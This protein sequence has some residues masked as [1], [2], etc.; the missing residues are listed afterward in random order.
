M[1][2]TTNSIITD[3]PST[4]MPTS[5]SIPPDCHQVQVFSTGGMT[6]C[7]S[8][9]ADS[10]P[11]SSAVVVASAPW[12]SDPVLSVVA[13]VVWDWAAAPADS[14]GLATTGDVAEGVDAGRTAALVS[15]CDSAA[16]TS[17]TYRIHWTPAPSA[18]MKHAASAAMPSSAPLYFSCLPNPRMRRND[19]KG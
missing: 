6:T 16:L 19:T 4:R 18:R 12:S 17:S 7:D 5:N 1:N 2:V 10:P 13:S 3:R 11:C 9:S 14:P 15:P 8:P